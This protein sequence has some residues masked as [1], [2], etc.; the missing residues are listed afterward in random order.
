MAYEVDAVIRRYASGEITAIQAASLLGGRT[1]VADV[2]LLLRQAGL[3]PPRPP[4]EQER[5][6]LEQARKILGMEP[7]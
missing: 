2:I 4:P 3:Q 7:K 1:T 6:A 5:A